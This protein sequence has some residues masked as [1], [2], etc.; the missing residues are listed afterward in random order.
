MLI[1]GVKAVCK[2]GEVTSSGYDRGKE[3]RVL[4]P[5]VKAV[6]KAGEVVDNAI[7]DVRYRTCPPLSIRTTTTIIIIINTVVSGRVQSLTLPRHAGVRMRN[8]T[9]LLHTQ[10]LSTLENYSTPARAIVT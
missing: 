6:C 1:P 2:A 5:G 9:H 3:R 7:T 8:T 4:I 10:S